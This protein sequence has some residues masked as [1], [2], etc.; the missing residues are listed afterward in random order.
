MF[1]KYIEEWKE[2]LK[3]EAK[4]KAVFP[5][6]LKIDP[7]C[8]FHRSEPIIVGVNVEKGVLH[9]GTLLCVKVTDDKKQT[10]ILTLGT[11]VSIEKNKKN[12]ESIREGEVAIKIEPRGQSYTFGRQFNHEHQLI[13][14]ISR[15]SIDALKN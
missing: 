15:E 2:R 3:A 8:V 9:V 13:S 1:M 7:Q 10:E 4:K 5:C 6:I 11:V 12:V 14:K